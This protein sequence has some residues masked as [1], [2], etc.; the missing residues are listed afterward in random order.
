MRHYANPQKNI[1]LWAVGL[2]L[3]IW[4][5]LS[6]AIGQEILLA[7]PVTVFQTLGVLIFEADF[8]YSVFLSLLRI[9]T[10]FL[11]AVVSS[12]IL[13]AAASRFAFIRDFL[14]PFITIMKSVPVASFVIL[15]LIWVSSR[16]LSIIISFFM[17]FPIL[18]E[19]VRQGIQQCDK[20]LLEMAQVFQI[21]SFTKVRYLYLSQV[22]PYFQSACSLSLGLC[23]KSGIAAEVIGLPEFSI[24]E[25][26]YQAK[27]YLD[28]SQLFA[29]TIVIIGISFLFERLFMALLLWFIKKTESEE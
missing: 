6:M 12:V 3:L 13:A 9:L 24:G 7:S 2:W 10:G 28:T 23:W 14:E 5:L 17:V 18:Y 20:R 16:H 29:W 21:D 27:I 8:W 26:L 11:S 1:R 15:L 25:R 4:Q 22:L 19:N